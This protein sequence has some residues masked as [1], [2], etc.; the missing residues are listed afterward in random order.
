M[1]NPQITQTLNAMMADEIETKRG[2][3]DCILDGYNQLGVKYDPI[4]LIAELWSYT[5]GDLSQILGDLIS[6]MTAEIFVKFG[7]ID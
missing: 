3:I 7:T 5:I 4:D 2:A 1:K 6:D